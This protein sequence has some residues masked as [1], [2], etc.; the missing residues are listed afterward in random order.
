MYITTEEV[1]YLDMLRYTLLTSEYHH[2]PCMQK[3]K[4]TYLYHSPSKYYTQ[5]PCVTINKVNWGTVND[6]SAAL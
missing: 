5:M 4:I 3:T 6:N 2:Y 1:C